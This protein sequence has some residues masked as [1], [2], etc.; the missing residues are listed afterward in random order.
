MNYFCCTCSECEFC[1]PHNNLGF[2]CAGGSRC[3]EEEKYRNTIIRN[4]AT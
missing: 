2:V 3:E 4:M 1:F